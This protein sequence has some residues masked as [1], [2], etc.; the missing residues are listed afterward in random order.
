MAEAVLKVGNS[1][2]M[3][4]AELETI[5][6]GNSVTFIGAFALNGCVKLVSFEIPESILEVG[7]KAFAE[8][9]S[10]VSVK[11]NG[12]LE[13][14]EFVKKGLSWLDD[15]QVEQVECSNGLAEID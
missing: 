2:F 13:Q 4:C 6:V 11:Y 3:D 10:L 7:F 1:A 8:C 9:E 5:T 14:W 15:T 12:T